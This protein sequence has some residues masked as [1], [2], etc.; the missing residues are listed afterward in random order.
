MS[1]ATWTEELDQGTAAEVSALIEAATSADGTPPVGEHVVMGLTKKGAHLLLH[2]GVGQAGK[3]RLVGY[4]QLDDEDFGAT[5]ELAVHPDARRRGVGT[6]LVQGLL[7][8][9]NG[10]EL[11]IWAHGEHPGALRLAQ[12]LEFR[13][14]RAL[15]QM[16]RS[17]S[18]PELAEPEFA[19]DVRV[20]TFV[21][22]QDEDEFL[23]V[24]NA[25]FDWH[26]EQG[27][28]DV[29]P[30]AERESEA[31]FDPAGFFLAEDAA[32]GRLL[33]Y[34]WTKV[35]TDPEHIGEVYV[36]GV[37]PTAQGRKLGAALTLAGLRHL[38]D[39]GLSDVLLYVEADNHAAVRVYEKLGFTRWHVDAQFSHEPRE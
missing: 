15:W 24:N 28:W 34:H 22:G 18:D 1:A 27:G 35:H 31:W 13:Q 20:R 37:D 38:R 17:L 6:Q 2:D 33:G 19:D 23:R 10:A 4:A 8:R 39:Q 21:V 25:A 14:I 16:R 11:R 9:A 36:L 7:D 26:P 3:D 29:T 12:R 5:A 30:L 32:T